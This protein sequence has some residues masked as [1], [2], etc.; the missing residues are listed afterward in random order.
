MSKIKKYSIW[1]FIIAVI[2]GG[3]VW[4]MKSKKPVTTYTTAEAVKGTLAQTVSV[5]GDL[6][7]QD[8][9]TLNF[10]IGG[11][12][13]KVFAKVSDKVA[14]GDEIATL[15]DATLQKQI[16]QAKAGLDQAIATSGGNSDTL[17][18]ANV[19]LNN[20]QDTLD[21]TESLNDQNISAAKEAVENAQNYYNDTKTYYDSLSEGAAKIQAKPTLTAAENGLNVAKQALKTANEQ[22]DLSE[23]AAQN[24]VDSAKARVKTVESD[25]ARSARNAQVAGAQAVYDMAMLNL[26]K[27]TLISPVNGIITEVNNK[28]GE[29]L[30]TG[31]IKEAFSRVMSMDMI[32]QSKVPESDIVKI[33]LGQHAKVTFDSLTADDIFDSEIIEIDPASTDVQGVVYYDIKLKLNTVDVRVKPGMSLNIDISTA[34]KNDVVSIPSRAIKIEGNKKYTDVLNTDGLTTKKVFVETGL[35]GNDGMVE[36]KSGLKGGE[37]VVTFQVTK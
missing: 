29:I 9:I 5:T 1:F 16:D 28:A 31:V 2:I 11:R 15:T 37:K 13:N 20:V 4:Y 21:Q 33:K 27:A 6:V 18:E 23:I 8:E 12:V 35:E 17:R 3:V 30:G 14:A 26:N 10:E 25:Y 34:E 24:A 36:I 22:T 32:I 19:S 7:A